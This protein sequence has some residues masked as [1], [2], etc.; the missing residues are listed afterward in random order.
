MID[1][2]KIDRKGR[3]LAS[4]IL[5]AALCTTTVLADNPAPTTPATRYRAPRT[6]DVS[7]RMAF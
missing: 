7:L 2:P 6:A 1:S 4:A 3:L 5:A